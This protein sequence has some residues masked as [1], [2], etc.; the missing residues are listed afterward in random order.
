MAYE[1]TLTCISLAAGS[2]MSSNQYKFV[3]LASDGQ[4]DL[5]GDGADVDGVLQDKPSAAGYSGQVAIAGVSKVVIGSGGVTV[6]D[7]VASSSAGTAITAATGDTI[8]GRAL[9]TA[10]AGTIGTVLLLLGNKA[11]LA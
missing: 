6:G 11:P 1:E 4:F 5:A 10:A 9:E 7:D 8:V 2:D 3:K